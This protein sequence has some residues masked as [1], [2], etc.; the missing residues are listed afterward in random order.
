MRGSAEVVSPATTTNDIREERR[1][2]ST[3]TAGCPSLFIDSPETMLV[4]PLND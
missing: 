3:S 1:L 2:G 4:N